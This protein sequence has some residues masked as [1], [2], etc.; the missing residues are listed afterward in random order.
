MFYSLNH[1]WYCQNVGSRRW[2]DSADCL[3]IFKNAGVPIISQQTKSWCKTEI[4][5]TPRFWLPWST[6]EVSGR[7]ES[8]PEMGKMRLLEVLWNLKPESNGLGHHCGWWKECNNA[9]YYLNVCVGFA[10]ALVRRM[11]TSDRLYTKSFEFCLW[12]PRMC[13]PA[14]G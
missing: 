8:L 2:Q 3:G 5:F 13:H 9:L 14:S 11:V 6:T 1:C 12:L 7:S 4:I 10:Y